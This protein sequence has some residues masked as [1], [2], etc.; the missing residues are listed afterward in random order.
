[1]ALHFTRTL[2][3]LHVCTLYYQPHFKRSGLYVVIHARRRH[4]T[5]FLVPIE[6]ETHAQTDTKSPTPMC[7][8]MAYVLV[9][10]RVRAL[11]TGWLRV[12][13]P[14][15]IIQCYDRHTSKSPQR[16]LPRYVYSFVCL[17]WH[18]IIFSKALDVLPGHT[19][20]FTSLL[21]VSARKLFYKRGVFFCT[22][23]T[24]GA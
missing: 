19:S 1:M 2:L 8:S 22:R 20:A 21:Q 23:A 16:V 7:A 11:Y 9:R 5:R 15:N 13:V 3:L 17:S 10:V 12:T 4:S 24:P 18:C 14:W 6:R